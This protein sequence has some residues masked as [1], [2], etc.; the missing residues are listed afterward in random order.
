MTGLGERSEIGWNWS[1]ASGI[2]GNGMLRRTQKME[3]VCRSGLMG[4]NTKGIGQ[5][6]WRMVRE[7]LFMEMEMCMK[8]IG[9][10]IK[11]RGTEFILI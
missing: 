4:V 2:R 11:L 3:G 10:K 7:D 1:K 8:E 9:Q 6:I 5:R